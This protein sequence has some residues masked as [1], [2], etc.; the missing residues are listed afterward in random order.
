MLPGSGVFAEQAVNASPELN[1][2]GIRHPRT[3]RSEHVLFNVLHI[4]GAD[5]GGRGVQGNRLRNSDVLVYKAMCYEP[6]CESCTSEECLLCR[7]CLTA[8]HVIMLKDSLGEQLNRLGMRRYHPKPMT[9]GGVTS[10]EYWR[11][12]IPKREQLNQAWFE[13]KC[14]QDT[15]WC[16]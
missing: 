8:D 1:F 12:Y 3:V 14:K 2:Q 15:Y 9:H 4:L 11:E 7:H 5:T 10:T 13:E 6:M 16:I